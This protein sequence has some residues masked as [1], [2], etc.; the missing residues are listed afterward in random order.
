M[1]NES[2]ERIRPAAQGQLRE[3]P[4][5]RLIQ[6]LFRKR[7]TGSLVVTDGDGDLTRAYLRDGFPVHIEAPSH[8]DRLD[9]ILMDGGVVR[10]DIVAR[11]NEECNRTGRRL[12]DILVS[13]KAITREALADVL[14]TQMRRKLTR[15]FFAR[16][17]TYEIF[18]ESHNFGAGDEF[19]LM[20]LDPRAILFPGIRSAY[21]DDRLREE[22]APLG[23][24]SFKLIATPV[25]FLQAMGFGQNDLT[26]SSLRART[27]TLDDLPRIGGKPVEARAVTLALLYSDLLEATAIAGRP[28]VSAVVAAE[29]AAIT[30]GPVVPPPG[31]VRTTWM[32]GG[33]VTEVVAPAASGRFPAATNTPARRMTPSGVPNATSAGSEFLRKTLT[34]LASKLGTTSHFEL[35]GLQENASNDEVHG[36]YM[37]AVRQFHPDRL[38]AVGL[39]DIAPQAEKVTARMGEAVAVLTDPKR[40]SDYVATRAGKKTDTGVA[41]AIIEAEKAFQKG[42]VFLKKG[43]FPRALEAF[44]EAVKTNP[45][46]PQYRAF[47]AWARFDDPRVRKESVARE[48][49]AALETAV[50]EEARFG[51]GHFWIAQIHKFLNDIDQAE[52]AF[53]AALKA[54]PGLVEAEREIRL[55]GMRKSKAA[56]T[57][58]AAPKGP[59]Q[60]A[61]KGGMFGKIFKG[62][63]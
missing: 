48:S 29:A 55:I 37:K 25:N 35:L 30:S 34:E 44:S 61:R 17:G 40:R 26:I 41:M 43:D 8:V 14:K 28:E 16:K 15:L 32:T 53:R 58:A 46:E 50:R 45:A 3:R 27:L 9:R 62:E 11:A 49:L 2:S 5:P 38:A 19:E 63:D 18:A 21:D 13:Q 54:D 10:A 57:R 6:Q 20:R 59:A 39:R 47:L 23:G 22:L 33:G 52:K 1:S 60:T 12:G 51:K 36:A 24:Y 42:E 4:V 31:A 7:I 56:E